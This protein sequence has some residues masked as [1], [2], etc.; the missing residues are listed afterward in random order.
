M[1]RLPTILPMLFALVL[2]TACALDKRP[3]DHAEYFYKKGRENILA[4][5]KEAD[6]SAAQ[7]DA[8]KRILERDRAGVIAAT[9]D[10]LQRHRRVFL[11]VATGAEAGE[12][13]Q[14]EGEFR[15]THASTLRIV[16]DMH[17]ALR[18]AVGDAVWTKARERM[19]TRLADI[20]KE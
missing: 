13:A 18:D 6:A 15:T 4:A 16:G 12:L 3:V 1:Q 5:L 2:M 11:G 20:Y 7:M 10:L 8:A 19:R 17:A 14:L 9:G